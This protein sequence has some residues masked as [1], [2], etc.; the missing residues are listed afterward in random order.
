MF[1]YK[2]AQ[3]AQP[4]PSPRPPMMKTTKSVIHQPAATPINMNIISR[5]GT[6]NIMKQVLSASKYK[7]AMTN[8]S[9]KSTYPAS[10][11]C[12]ASASDPANWTCAIDDHYLH[13][14]TMVR[15]SRKNMHNA[16]CSAVGIVKPVFRQIRQIY[17]TYNSLRCLDLQI[18]R[19]FLLTTVTTTARPI[20]LHLRMR[21]G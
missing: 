2:S 17:C 14:R 12:R 8:Q 21:V 18:W 4:L 3:R 10:T 1:L 20:T 16:Q 6:M 5:V 19:Y 9:S 11:Q 7:I 13:C 15:M